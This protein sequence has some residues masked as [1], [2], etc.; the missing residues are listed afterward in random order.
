MKLD[1]FVLVN[2]PSLSPTSQSAEIHDKKVRPVV[3]TGLVDHCELVL[4]V[5]GADNCEGSWLSA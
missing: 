5:I 3:I 2:S 4:G 1:E